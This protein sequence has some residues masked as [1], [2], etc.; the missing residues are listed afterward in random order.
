MSMGLALYD[1]AGNTLLLNIIDESN[2]D[3][4]GSGIGINN[5]LGFFFS[6]LSPMI[7]CPLGEIDVFLPFY[8][9]I[10]LVFI[11]LIVTIKFL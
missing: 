9:L 6:S 4:K 3:L 10:G 7:V 1:P 11:A 8:L 5:A 2:P